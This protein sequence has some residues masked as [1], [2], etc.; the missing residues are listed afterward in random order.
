VGTSDVFGDGGVGG[1]I[2]NSVGIDFTG[3]PSV[4]T[5]DAPSQAIGPI[6]ALEGWGQTIADLLGWSGSGSPL[7]DVTLPIIP[8]DLLDGGTSAASAAAD[9]LDGGTSAAT[10]AADLSTLWQDLLAAF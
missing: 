2:F 10:V 1:S 8:T 9:F 6:G 4:T 3:V 7:A 5:L